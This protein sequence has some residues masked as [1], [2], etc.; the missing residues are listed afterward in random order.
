MILRCP[1]P[2]ETRGLFGF[3]YETQPL[4]LHVFRFPLLILSVSDRQQQPGARQWKKKR[5]QKKVSGGLGSPCSPRPQ[6]HHKNKKQT[7]TQKNTTTQTTQRPL[8]PT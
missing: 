2:R 3:F 4:S 8:E 6:K 1:G 5:I 7:K